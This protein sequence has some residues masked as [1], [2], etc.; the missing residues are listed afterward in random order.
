MEGQWLL[1]NFQELIDSILN[2]DRCIQEQISISNRRRD[3]S[4]KVSFLN[5]LLSYNNINKDNILEVISAIHNKFLNKINALKEEDLV[6]IMIERINNEWYSPNNILVESP[7]QSDFF[8]NNN[9]NRKYYNRS[10]NLCDEVIQLSKI[11]NN[12]PL[13]LQKGE[14]HPLNN[15]IESS[16]ESCKESIDYLERNCK[17][18]ES[19]IQSLKDVDMTQLID[20]SIKHKSL[21]LKLS[22]EDGEGELIPENI[23]RIFS[24]YIHI[25]NL[26]LKQMIQYFHNLNHQLN[27]LK[28]RCKVMVNLKQNVNSIAYLDEEEEEEEAEDEDE[29]EDEGELSI[30]DGKVQMKKDDS[31]LNQF[32]SFF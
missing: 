1:I 28:E 17:M 5:Q 13:K 29:D 10:C 11:E 23:H 4:C 14:S 20:L 3:A 26:L 2:G 6:Q 18:I 31:I 21:Y 16:I 22:E 12:I 32:T 30:E 15:N 24:N 25:H 19:I 7:L 8:D 27:E 9:Q